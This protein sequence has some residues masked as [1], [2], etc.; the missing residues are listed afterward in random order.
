MV[1]VEPSIVTVPML[2][3]TNDD[4]LGMQ[5]MLYGNVTKKRREIVF[6]LWEP[7]NC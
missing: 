4:S 3:S 7:E 1:F 2:N 6:L 5:R